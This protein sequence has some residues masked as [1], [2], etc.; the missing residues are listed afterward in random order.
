MLRGFGLSPILR[1][2]L[3]VFYKQIKEISV[4]DILR[5]AIP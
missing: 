5:I 3:N 4:S 1:D 2:E